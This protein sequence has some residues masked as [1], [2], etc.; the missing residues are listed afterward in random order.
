MRVRTYTLLAAAILAAL[1]APII[2]LAHLK[3]SV[4]IRRAPLTEEAKA[5]QSQ[6]V[7]SDA[8]MSAA[9]NFLGDTVTYLDATV[10]NNGTRVVHQLDLQLEFVDMLNQVVLRETAH[11]VT[12]ETPPLMAGESRPFRVTFE[13]MPAEWNQAPPAVTVT[14]VAF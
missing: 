12:A 9:R 10:V 6:I 8:R 3:S 4:P 1:L 11:A 7:V 2:W 14:Y 13:H 5:Y